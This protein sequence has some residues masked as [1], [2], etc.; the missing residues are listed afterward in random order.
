MI[1]FW[2]KGNIFRNLRMK[3]LGSIIQLTWT[4]LFPIV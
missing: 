4:Y 2:G 3:A 1:A